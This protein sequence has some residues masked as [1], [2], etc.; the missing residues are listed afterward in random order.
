MR[1]SS[2]CS[3]EELSRNAATAYR[4]Y[5]AARFPSKSPIVLGMRWLRDVLAWTKDWLKGYRTY[6]E[7]ARD[8]QGSGRKDIRIKFLGLWD[9]VEAYGF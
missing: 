2:F 1:A 8:I 6:D 3:E 7:M 5:R 9:T 4:H